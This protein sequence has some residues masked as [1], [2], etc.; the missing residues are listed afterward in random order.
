MTDTLPKKDM[1][2]E[3]LSLRA[4][5]VRRDVLRLV[6]LGGSGE[7]M[8][9]LSLVE[10]LV[11]LYWNF[12]R[13]NPRKPLDPEQDRFLLGCVSASS[14]HYAVLAHAGFF[15]REDLWSCGKLGSVLQ[16]SPDIR[17]TPGIK[18]PVSSNGHILGIA[19]GMALGLRSGGADFPKASRVVACLNIRELQEGVAWEAL[20][21]ARE[22]SLENLCVVVN[23]PERKGR[24]LPSIW[25]D[26]ARIRSRMNL[27]GWE[28]SEGNGHDYAYL[29]EAF[30]NFEKE[31]GLLRGIFLHTRA[32]RGLPSLEESGVSPDLSDRSWLAGALHELERFSEKTPEERS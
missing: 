13:I 22:F 9:S 16:G 28:T 30:G 20:R 14:V 8:E 23:C 10:L 3:A 15:P 29:A 11:F 2:P 24:E 18:Y 26:M 25:L 1:L 27:L 7:L 31:P 6:S 32:G 5:E 19:A 21:I 17:R 12:L 4:L